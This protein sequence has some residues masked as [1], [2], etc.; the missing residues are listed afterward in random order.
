MNAPRPLKAGDRVA[1]IAPSS[2]FARE[3]Y[4]AMRSALSSL[5]FL[6]APGEHVHRAK[7]YLAGTDVERAEDLIRVIMDP[8]V[9]AIFCI[10]GGY[11][12]GRLLPWLPF[13]DL[14]PHRKVFVGHSDLTFLHSAFTSRMKWTTFLGP[15][16]L[17]LAT[18]EGGLEG[19]LG[20]F[21]T[22]SE[23]SWQFEQS[24]V[25][26]HGF[27][28]GPLFGGNLTCFTHLLG[29]P[30]FP[31]L[32]GA[33]LLLEDRGEALYRIDR[34]LTHLKLA[35]AFDRLQGLVLGQFTDCAST[36]LLFEMVLDV[37]RPFSFPIVADLP[38]GH[39]ARNEVVPL[40]MP[41]KLSTHE[42]VL[43][44]RHSPFQAIS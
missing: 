41:F 25:L 6:T 1:L 19:F 32:D 37:L 38:F 16:L 42:R 10:R 17:D 33:M 11:G 22:S 9:A 20:A 34:M 26:R 28:S 30:Y 4:E 23:F 2:P 21:S 18:V 15:N 7:G 31:N 44:S 24:Q 5:G 27:A 14:A 13:A 29:T 39:A 43:Q 35:G 36:D 12:S 8:D 40:G 3:S